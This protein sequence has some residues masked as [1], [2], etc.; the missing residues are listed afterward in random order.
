M[1]RKLGG[2]GNVPKLLLLV[3]A[4]AVYPLLW[5]RSR[6]RWL[7]PCGGAIL[8]AVYAHSECLQYVAGLAVDSEEASIA[9]SYQGFAF[10]AKNVVIAGALLTYFVYE[11]RVSKRRRVLGKR[12]AAMTLA[13]KTAGESPASEGIQIRG[14]LAAR[15]KTCF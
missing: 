11:M 14:R 15:G 13:A 6:W 10:A 9:R 2:A 1:A 3:A 5:A 7:A 4:V 12:L 8:V